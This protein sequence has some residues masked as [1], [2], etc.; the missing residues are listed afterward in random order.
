MSDF[1]LDF[2]IDKLKKQLQPAIEQAGLNAVRKL[3]ERLF[4]AEDRGKLK[5]FLV[6]G[7]IQVDGP[8]SLIDR[9]QKELAK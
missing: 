2:S 3:S 5:I 1:K 6:N 9:L 4:T 7:K 8:Q